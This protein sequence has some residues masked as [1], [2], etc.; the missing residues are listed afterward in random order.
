MVAD[1][2]NV[3]TSL[4]GVNRTLRLTPDSGVSVGRNALL[5]AIETPL[6]FL[7]VDAF[8]ICNDGLA[9]L[10]DI[11]HSTETDIVAPRLESPTQAEYYAMLRNETA[12]A[13]FSN[14]TLYPQ[15]IQVRGTTCVRTNYVLQHY[16][17]RVSALRRV[18][19]DPLLRMI[20]HEDFMIRADQAGL[21]MLSCSGVRVSAHLPNTE[22]CPLSEVYKSHRGNTDLDNIRTMNKHGLTQMVVNWKQLTLNPETGQLEELIFNEKWSQITDEA[23]V[24]RCAQSALYLHNQQVSQ[25]APHP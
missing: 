2:S 21:H 11:M 10:V 1:D 14:V 18:R 7:I 3:A 24:V 6:L 13:I 19:W 17:G 8:M 5:D 12:L 4:R 15:P 16:L 23:E 25:T 22:G 9:R 20:D